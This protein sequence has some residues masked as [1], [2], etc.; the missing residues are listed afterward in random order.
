LAIHKKGGEKLGE[1]AS[2]FFILEACAL[3][4]YRKGVSADPNE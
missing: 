4:Y 3:F 2:R 1:W